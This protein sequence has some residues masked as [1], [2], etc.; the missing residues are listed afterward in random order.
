[1]QLFQY[2][3]GQS[4]WQ[5]ISW[6]TS[7]IVDGSIGFTA[8][9][10]SLW[11]ISWIIM[12][13]VWQMRWG[14][15]VRKWRWKQ[16]SGLMELRNVKVKTK[17]IKRKTEWQREGGR[18]GLFLIWLILSCQ[19]V[20]TVAQVSGLGMTSQSS[21]DGAW[22]QWWWWRRRGWFYWQC[23]LVSQAPGY[24]FHIS[25]WAPGC[26]YSSTLWLYGHRTD[27][28]AG[29]GVFESPVDLPLSRLSLNY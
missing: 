19:I 14:L 9:L 2:L 16:R 18:K 25:Q 11:L 27:G 20:M 24:P 26:A 7:I 22:C 17:Q 23:W 28:E 15:R 3:A 13:I 5:V 4:C 29:R 6:H 10:S 12:L 21:K 1:M 8:M